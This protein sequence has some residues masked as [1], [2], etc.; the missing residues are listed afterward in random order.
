MYKYINFNII[1]Q[2]YSWSISNGVCE[3]KSCKGFKSLIFVFFTSQLA[4][5][6]IEFQVSQFIIIIIKKKEYKSIVNVFNRI[7]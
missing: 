2:V 3:K 5:V 7:Y 6:R 1:S 4:K